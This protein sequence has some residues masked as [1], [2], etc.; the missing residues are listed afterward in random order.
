ME[1]LKSLQQFAGRESGDPSR[2]MKQYVAV[3]KAAG[4]VEE[5]DLLA[6]FPAVCESKTYQQ[7]VAY[8]AFAA[9]AKLGEV[10]CLLFGVQGGEMAARQAVMECRQGPR[11]VQEYALEFG[12]LVSRIANQDIDAWLGDFRSR[13]RVDVAIAIA[14]HSTASFAEAVKKACE[15][16]GQLPKASS[17]SSVPV[18]V[19]SLEARVA[20][21]TAEIASFRTSMSKPKVQK[22]QERKKQ[23]QYI[24]LNTFEATELRTVAGVNSGVHQVYV[25]VMFR[26]KEFNAF[27][28]TGAEVSLLSEEVVRKVNLQ[29]LDLKHPDAHAKRLVAIGGGSIRVTGVV[30]ADFSV[31]G[32]CVKRHQFHVIKGLKYPLL[33]GMDVLSLVNL[34][35]ATSTGVVRSATVLDQRTVSGVQTQQTANSFPGDSIPARVPSGVGVAADL[36]VPVRAEVNRLLG[37]FADCFADEHNSYGHARCPPLFFEVS[38][39]PPCRTRPYAMS[40]REVEFAKGMVAEWESNGR[41]RPSE[42]SWAASLLVADKPMP[43]GEP[44]GMRLVVDLKCL[45]ERILPDNQPVP[46]ARALFDQLHGFQ[47]LMQFDFANAYLQMEVAEECRKYLSFVTPWGAQYEFCFVPFGLNIAGGALQ[48]RLGAAFQSVPFALGYADDWLIPT[49]MDQLPG[50]LKLFLSAV[51]RSGFL[52]KPSKCKIGFEKLTFLGRVVSPSGLELHPDDVECINGWPQPS[53]KHSLM[54]FLGVLRWCAEF[55]PE[56]FEPSAKIL[57]TI[58]KPSVKFVWGREHSEAFVRVKEAAIHALRLSFPDFRKPFILETDA[59][60]SGFGA[61]LTQ[62]GK[63]VRVAHRRTTPAEAGLP[64]TFLELSCVVWAVG[65][66]RHYLHGRRFT[67]LTDHRALEW[68]RKPTVRYGKLTLWALELNDFIFDIQYTPGHLMSAADALSRR[69]VVGR[70]EALSVPTIQD[71]IAAQQQDPTCVDIASRLARGERRT[72]EGFVV[73]VD[74]VVCSLTMRHSYPVL[75]PI[76]PPSLQQSVLSAV[77]EK[78]AHLRQGTIEMAKSN[79]HWKGIVQD[80]EKFCAS[81]ESCLRSKHP[82]G[83]RQMPEGTVVATKRNEFVACDLLQY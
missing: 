4:I 57:M 44:V 30:Y 49:G 83:Q 68:L 63:V 31:Q 62:D 2:W 29:R 20:E 82:T 22:K 26:T 32:L 65:Y 51:R 50:R 53:D 16:E 34:E 28:D 9:W 80:A 41:I 18:Q 67:I 21:L 79:F 19:S 60:Q 47:R 3:C 71:I 6:N 59:S 54:R 52:L 11:S 66:F 27:V 15:I 73:D 17:S 70:I 40:Q 33:L 48:R 78:A 35:I 81:C 61:L 12:V 8:G 14:G 43:D 42:S 55:L 64:A 39:G 77:H 36:P 58:A 46:T 5:A 7:L 10:M 25:P 23:D 38:E 13:L 75:R 69:V 24:I 72:T 74:G 37:D 1:K 56:E 76:V 45:N